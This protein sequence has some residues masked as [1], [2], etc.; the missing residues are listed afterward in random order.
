MKTTNQQAQPELSP[1]EV[2]ALERV[3]ARTVRRWVQ[4]GR[5]PARRILGGTL[6]RIPANYRQVAGG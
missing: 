1:D 6:I 4:Q 2:A 3:S 5:L